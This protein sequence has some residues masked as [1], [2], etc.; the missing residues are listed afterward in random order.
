MGVRARSQRS[1]VPRSDLNFH[2]ALQKPY[3]TMFVKVKLQLQMFCLL[4][5]L[6]TESRTLRDFLFAAYF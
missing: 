4:T 3:N 1:M 2:C 5:T 6:I